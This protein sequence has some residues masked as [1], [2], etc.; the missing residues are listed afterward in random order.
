MRHWRSHGFPVRKSDHSCPRFPGGHLIQPGFDHPNQETFAWM[1]WLTAPTLSPTRAR[2]AL[3][4]FPSDLLASPSGVVALECYRGRTVESRLFPAGRNLP[5]WECDKSG[6]FDHY[7]PPHGLRR[8]NVCQRPAGDDECGRWPAR[9]SWGRLLRETALCWRCPP[10]CE[11]RT[12]DPVPE[13]AQRRPLLN[14]AG[15]YPK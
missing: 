8:E 6:E 11:T 15:Y 9:P 13:C 12:V 10:G 14:Y 7:D 1:T 3:A 4:R 5:S 2:A